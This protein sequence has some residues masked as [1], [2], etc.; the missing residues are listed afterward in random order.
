MT[1]EIERLRAAFLAYI[2]P[3]NECAETGKPCREPEKCG[4]WKEMQNW[5]DGWGIIEGLSVEIDAEAKNV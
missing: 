5:I 3:Q 1:D 4:C 2:Q